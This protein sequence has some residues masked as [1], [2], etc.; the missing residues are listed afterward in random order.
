MPS[1][2]KSSAPRANTLSV[3]PVK[4]FALCSNRFVGN[5]Y[6]ALGHHDLNIPIAQ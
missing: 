2:T 5:H 3:V 6:A 1:V 4:F